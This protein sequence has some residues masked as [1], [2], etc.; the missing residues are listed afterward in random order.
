LT[1]ERDLAGIVRFLACVKIL[2][3]IHII[4]PTYEFDVS[5]ANI[6]HLFDADM[7]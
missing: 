2:L 6:S 5:L 1:L 7:Y 3:Q 4:L